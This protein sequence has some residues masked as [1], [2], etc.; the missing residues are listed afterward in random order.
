MRK[1]TIIHLLFV[2]DNPDMCT[3]VADFCERIGSFTVNI[4]NSGESALEWL[5]TSSVDVIVS[6]YDMPGGMNGIMLL[7]ELHSRGNTTPFILFTAN[8]TCNMRE[9]AYRNGAFSVI[10]KTSSGKNPIHCLVRTIYWAELY[11]GN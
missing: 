7:R 4:L 9:E 3:I 6:D 8:D 1:S 5:S 11:T 2:D 10:N